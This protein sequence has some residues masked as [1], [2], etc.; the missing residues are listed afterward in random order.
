MSHFIYNGKMNGKLSSGKFKYYS[1]SGKLDWLCDA[2]S[3]STNL[4]ALP[5][6]LYV[7]SGFRVMKEK[8]FVLYDIGFGFDLIPKFKTDRS[9]LMFHPDGNLPGTAGCIGGLFRDKQETE[10]S[11]I[12]LKKLFDKYKQI[13]VTV[14]YHK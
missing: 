11:F 9:E 4:K 8:P 2:I 10:A 6:G 12:F 13:P 14:T 7:A 5:E 1:E 3:G